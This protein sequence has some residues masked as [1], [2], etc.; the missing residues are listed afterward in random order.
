MRVGRYGWNQECAGEG[1]LL[2]ESLPWQDGCRRLPPGSKHATANSTR[3]PLQAGRKPGSGEGTTS[4]G[5]M[6]LEAERRLWVALAARALQQAG[7][8][9]LAGRLFE[10]VASYK[11]ARAMLAGMGQW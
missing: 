9:E 3:C 4:S 2:L 5:G 6:T 11:Q 7:E 1:P 10:S 8:R